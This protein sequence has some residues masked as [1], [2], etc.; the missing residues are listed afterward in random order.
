MQN[1]KTSFLNDAGHRLAGILD[2]PASRPR[3]F[4]LFAH[5]FTCGKDLKSAAN[6]SA[7]MTAADIGVLRFDFT[8]LG[9]SGGEFT[10]T[11]FSS[12]VA[13]LLAAAKFLES[14]YEAPA[15]LVGHSLGG[16]AVLQAAPRI[17]SAVAVATIGAPA[18]PEHVARLFGASRVDIEARGVAEVRLAGRPFSIRR[19][20]LDDLREHDLPQAISRLRKALLLLHAPLDSIVDVD[21]AATL[22]TAAKHPKSFISLDRADHLLTNGEDST[23]A[24]QVVAA[25]AS[26]FLPVAATEPDVE[27]PE[28]VVVAQTPIDSL[29]TEI[30]AGP[31]HLIADEP[32]S[33]GGTEL[34]P[35]P[36]GLLSAALAAC[37]SMTLKMYAKHKKLDVDSV[38][39][40]VRHRKIHAE[41]CSDCESEDGRVDEFQREIV[42]DGTVNDDQRARLLQIADRCPVH[43]TL[44]SEV[45]IRTRE[46]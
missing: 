1:I 9:Q 22:F 18:S 33:L 28:G 46:G 5:C 32:A 19:E 13:D 36:Y 26:R 11:S 25:W 45:K 31:H 4:A 17:P 6:I 15:I 38:T 43:R 8:G 34:G 7:A 37:T 44:E 30:K 21:N 14:E 27:A 24:G 16:T 12:N 39:V 20:F 10:D 42:V 23:Y 40:K 35:T 3:A 29:R 41:D 2:L